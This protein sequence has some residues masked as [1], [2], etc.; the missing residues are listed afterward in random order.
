[1]D[2]LETQNAWGAL[3]AARAGGNIYTIESIRGK[4]SYLEFSKR[5]VDQLH[6]H[7]D[8]INLT[9]FHKF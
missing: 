6:L 2:F 5:P 1:M 7:P 8:V 3:G 9:G 4:D